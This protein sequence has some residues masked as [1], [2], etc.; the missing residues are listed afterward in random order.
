VLLDFTN[1]NPDIKAMDVNGD[2]LVDLVYSASTSYQTFFALGRYAGGVD[3]YGAATPTSATTATISN[4]PVTTCIPSSSGTVQLSGTDVRVAD[5]NGDGLPDIVRVR[6]NQIK[7]WPGRGN[8]LWGTGLL[9]NCPAGLV[10][11]NREITMA[12][13]PAFTQTGAA[14]RLVDVNGD[15]LDDLV[16]VRSGGIDIWLN[17]D[18]SG[19]T[20]KSHAVASTIG[21][22]ANANIRIADMNGSGTRDIL[23]ADGGNYRYVDLMGGQR[24][25]LLTEV[26]NGLGKSTTFQYRSSVALM[27]AAAQSG[28][29]WQSVT[30][31][32]LHVLTRLTET[33]NLAVAGRAAASYVTDY[34]YRDPVYDGRQREFRGFRDVQSIH[35]G[36]ANSPTS[37]TE[38]QYLLGECVEETG[39]TPS[40]DASDLWRDN[41]REALKGL[42]VTSD[43][44]DENGVYQATTHNTY[45]LRRLYVGVD[46]REVRDVYA[47]ATDSW[48]YDT[49]A[50]A[51]GS[52]SQTLPTVEL[53]LQPGAVQPSTSGSVILRTGSGIAHVRKRA[54]LDT[55]GNVTDTIDD[56]CVDGCLAVDESLT[57][58]TTPGLPADDTGGWLWRPVESWTTGGTPTQWHH[59]YTDFDGHGEPTRVSGQLTGSLPLDRFHEDPTQSVAPAPADAS[60]D[61]VIVLSTTQYDAFGNVSALTGAHGRCS[62]RAYDSDFAQLVTVETDFVGAPGS[63]GCGTTALQALAGWDRGQMTPTMVVDLHGELTTLSYDGFG[64]PTEIHKP[65]PALVGVVS[66]SCRRTRRRRRGRWC[67]RNFKLVPTSTA[68]S[69]ATAGRIRTGWDARS[70]RSRRLIHRP[71]IVAAGS[72]VA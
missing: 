52:T 6:P 70:W 22:G 58:H 47:S 48:R 38:N 32:P 23:W 31:M 62:S 45:R 50:G 67:I 24:P 61:G 42:P 25:W 7:Y 33:D 63:D 40:C 66:S 59:Q 9:T 72:L 36:D 11:I 15:G 8:G 39:G 49:S 13:A 4:S 17:V 28:Q 46:G 44:F 43:T 41:P 3:Q 26:D 29:P 20:S 71:A 55:F 12:T 54:V 57:S 64:R 27:Q 51:M 69:I 65:S 53:E 16:Q 14:I 18:G 21:A 5:M 1:H 2:G 37:I 35:R 30:P 19:W 34:E 10:G 68:Q 60:Q 56:G